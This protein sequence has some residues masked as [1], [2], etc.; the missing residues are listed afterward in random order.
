MC[1][2]R[3]GGVVFLDRREHMKDNVEDLHGILDK[4]IQFLYYDLE[5]L[6]KVIE[7]FPF[8]IQI[9]SSD[10][11]SRLINRAALE[12]ICIKSVETH[13]N[14]YNVFKDPV[15]RSLGYTERVRQVLTGK[16]V[17]IVDFNAPYKELLR[18]YDVRDEDIDTIRSD[19]YC[20]PIKN[21]SG[22][23]EYFAAVF[24]IKEVYIGKEEIS[25]GKQYIENHWLEP[26]D[27][28]KT[29]KAACLSKSHF[30][31]LFKKHTGITPHE[32]YI[33]IKI[34]KLKEKLL[35]SNLSIAEAFA[36][37]NIDYNGYYA[38]I[39]RKKT[40]MSPSALR[41]NSKENST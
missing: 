9:F 25:K 29:A 14:I 11:T 13:V 6:A 3:L 19:I 37:C 35:D 27:A 10:G 18:Y 28:G 32:Y 16:T 36:S 33:N 23:V 22:E 38:R 12:M 21:A 15:V 41:K 26:F 2:Y 5:L 7:F 30:T 34:H 24:I 8:P 39:F 31:K 17:E 20:F 40:G 1:S 4:T